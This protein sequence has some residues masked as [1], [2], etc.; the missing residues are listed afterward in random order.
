MSSPAKKTIL[1][2]GATGRQ[3]SGVITALLSSPQCE[4]YIILAVTRSPASAAAQKL[5]TLSSSIHLVQGDL[6]DIPALF[7]SA[8]SLSPTHKIWGVFSVQ[9][10]MGPGVTEASEIR[11]GSALIDASIEHGVRMFA[12]SSV[13]RG[14]DAAS[15]DNE[16]PVSHFRSKHRVERHL[17]SA[18][19]EQQQQQ[20]SS[21]DS[22]TMGGVGKGK[23]KGRDMMW[24]VLRPVAFMD[25]LRPGTFETGVFLAA[26]RNKMPPGKRLQWI[27]SSDVGPY[28]ALAFDRPEEWD[29]RAVGLAGDELTMDELGRVFEEAVGR[30]APVAY[31]LFGSVLTALVREMGLMIGWFATDGYRA[32]V[33]ARRAEYPALMDLGAYLRGNTE[34]QA[35][36]AR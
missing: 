22:E 26:L 14:G 35:V 11:Q 24:T 18:T 31:W 28:A 7:S 4:S 23:G 27:A 5:A 15:W 13:E 25:N 12:Y 10:S 2:T 29:G 36:A 9:V 21:S 16:T 33:K 30:P 32:D 20:H 3:G 19:T 17:R 8:L 34:W 6:N 1:V